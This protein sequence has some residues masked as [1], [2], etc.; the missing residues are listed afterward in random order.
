MWAN[1]SGRK[2][3]FRKPGK[4]FGA[5]TAVGLAAVGLL[6]GCSSP[7]SDSNSPDKGYLREVAVAAVPFES[8]AVAVSVGHSM[9][10]AIERA[11]QSGRSVADAKT[12]AK[13]QSGRAGTYSEYQSTTIVVAAVGSY[14]PEYTSAK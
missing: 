9:C 10:D 12:I 8:D 11:V 7:P 3:R 5:A 2:V 13:Q 4:R 6:A 14:C 1:N